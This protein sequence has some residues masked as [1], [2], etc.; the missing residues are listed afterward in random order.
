MRPLHAYLPKELESRHSGYTSPAFF[1]A[2]NAEH[3]EKITDGYLAPT[4]STSLTWTEWLHNLC[5]TFTVATAHHG[6]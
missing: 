1:G 2:L 3:E 6:E 4:L 5:L